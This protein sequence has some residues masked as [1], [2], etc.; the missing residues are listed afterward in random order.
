VVLAEQE[1]AVVLVVALLLEAL[2]IKVLEL[3]VRVM[4]EELALIMAPVV[5]AVR[6]L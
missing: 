5:V 6:V 2:L 4:Q 1:L 3:L